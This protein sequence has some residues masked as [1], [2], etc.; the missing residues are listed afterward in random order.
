MTLLKQIIK[1]RSVDGLTDYTLNDQ[2]SLRSHW[3]ASPHYYIKVETADGLFGADISSE[4]NPIP[5]AIGERSGT[6]YRK[7]KG[8]SL[9]GTIEGRTIADM[10]AASRYLQRAFWE[11]EPRKLIYNEYEGTA[12]YFLCRVL[13]DL[14]V[15]VTYSIQNPRW[16]WTVGLRCDDPRQRKLSDNTLFYS[17]MT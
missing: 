15:S 13:N 2:A 8:I 3:S 11:A 1:Y 9:N 17:W 5:H 7:G 10:E 4:S 6:T 12:C 14:S 16:S